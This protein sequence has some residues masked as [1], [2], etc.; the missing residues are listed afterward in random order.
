MKNKILSSIVLLIILVFSACDFVTIPLEKKVVNPDDSTKTIRKVLLEDYTGHTCT[1]CPR[2]A[3]K[4]VELKSIYGKKL[5]VIAV[6]AS[7]WARPQSSGTEYLKDFRT[8]AGEEYDKFFKVS[9]AGYPNGLV[10]RTLHNGKKIIGD[11]DWSTVVP[12]E[13]EKT[14][15]FKIE[16]DKINLSNR[17]IDFM[18]KYT[19]LENVSTLSSSYKLSVV[20]IQDNI[21]G[22]QKN[23]SG[24]TMTGYEFNHVLRDN[25]NGTW[26]DN[27]DPI[28]KNVEQT[29]NFSYVFPAAYNYLDKTGTGIN[30]STCEVKK[31]HII[32]YI[33]DDKTK[34]VMQVEEAEIH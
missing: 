10:N 20:V 5:V 32:A 15:L 27:L 18:V 4:A 17:T 33:Y 25:I 12:K 1:N 9:P 2:A 23:A 19:P 30:A 13:L 21:V 29:K 14:A 28:S 11:G 26:G 24:Q 34:E 8:V 7:G 16:F 3:A 31:C 6:H 22:E